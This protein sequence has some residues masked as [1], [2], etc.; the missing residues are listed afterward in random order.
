MKS[1]HAELMEKIRENPSVKEA[2]KKPF[3]V[4]G[5]DV[6]NLRKAYGINFDTFIDF[7]NNHVGTISSEHATLLESNKHPI[8]FLLYENIYKALLHH[9]GR[10][11]SADKLFLKVSSSNQL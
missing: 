11:E 2:R 3:L 7:L 1:S 10:I 4:K 5:N 6:K 8:D 9:Y